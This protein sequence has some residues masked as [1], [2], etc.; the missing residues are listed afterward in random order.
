MNSLFVRVREEDPT[1]SEI[2]AIREVNERAFGFAAR[3]RARSVSFASGDG[4]LFSRSI[5]YLQLP[6]SETRKL[7]GD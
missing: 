6:P 7:L 2:A 1:D 3:R 4:E 5:S